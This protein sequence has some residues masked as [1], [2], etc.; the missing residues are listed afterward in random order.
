MIHVYHMPR[1]RSSRVVWTAQEVGAKIDIHPIDLRKGEGQTPEHKER[2]PHGKLPATRIEGEHL[3]ESGAI[4]LHL[5]CRYAPSSAFLPDLA[6]V[7]GAK[8]LQWAFYAVSTLDDLT[9]DAFLQQFAPEEKRN[10]ALVE[11][12]ANA[13]STTIAPFLSRELGDGPYLL[14]EDFTFAD[15][16][17]GYTTFYASQMGWLDGPLQAYVGR[18]TE[19]PGFKVAF[20]G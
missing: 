6:S 14:G 9:L 15:V 16:M 1:T 3:I 4:A 10:Q 8:V 12:A 11:R 20:E 7:K 2:H 19:R 18:L 5:A 17:V 13:W